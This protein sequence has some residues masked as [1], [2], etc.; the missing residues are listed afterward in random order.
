M[1]ANSSGVGSYVSKVPSSFKIIPGMY[2][3]IESLIIFLTSKY[4]SVNFRIQGQQIIQQGHPV[5]K[6]KTKA[7]G[8]RM[9]Q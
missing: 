1:M 8:S 9:K 4:L 7:T 6:A 2:L 3:F 5:P